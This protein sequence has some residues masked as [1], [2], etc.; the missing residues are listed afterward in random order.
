MHSFP[1]IVL[2]THVLHRLMSGIIPIK[3]LQVTLKCIGI[4]RIEF[5]GN[6]WYVIHAGNTLANKIERKY[7]V[8]AMAVHVKWTGVLCW[9]QP[10]G[11]EAEHCVLPTSLSPHCACNQDEFGAPCTA[12]QLDGWVTLWEHYL[13]FWFSFHSLFSFGDI[14]WLRA[15]DPNPAESTIW[16]CF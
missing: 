16:G 6:T 13:L 15:E 2:Y 7:T 10:V 14:Q 5:D 12:V 9:A 1:C 8:D 4:E 3:W 11:S